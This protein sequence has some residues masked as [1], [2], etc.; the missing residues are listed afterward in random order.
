MKTRGRQRLLVS[1][2][3]TAGAQESLLKLTGGQA[4]WE[5]KNFRGNTV[6]LA[7]GVAAAAGAVVGAA[8]LPAP[9]RAPAVL[10]SGVAAVTGCADDFAAQPAAAKGLKGHLKALARGE[11]TTG[12][13]K[14]L[15]IS[16][17][18]VLGGGMIARGRAGGKANFAVDTL[19]SGALIAG[20]ANLINLFDLRPGRALKVCTAL[21]AGIAADPRNQGGHALAHTAAGVALGAAPRDLNETTMLG[22]VGANALGAL[23]GVALASHPGGRTRAGALAAVTGLILASEKVSFSKVIETRPALARLDAWGRTP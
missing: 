17:A 9:L 20:T 22:D 3:L 4:A 5:R 1:A 15:G 19:T 7:G 21:A 13:V 11:L 12:A 16:A 23:L 18:A 14:L 10:V 8:R 6:S 2:A